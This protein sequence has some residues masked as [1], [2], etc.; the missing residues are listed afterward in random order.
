MASFSEIKAN[1]RKQMK[2]TFLSFAFI[3]LSELG[4][5]NGLWPIQIRKIPSGRTRV[6]GCTPIVSHGS[7]RPALRDPH[8]QSVVSG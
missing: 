2:A 7:S 1:K 5:F 3:Y 8:S 6:S 4:L